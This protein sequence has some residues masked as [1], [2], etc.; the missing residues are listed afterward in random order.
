MTAKQFRDARYVIGSQRVV[1]I[2][3]GINF[4]TLQHVES[5]R[6]GDPIPEKYAN[7]IRG[8]EKQ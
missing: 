4:T 6:F 3:L 7:M 5:G 2:A 1:A 8:L